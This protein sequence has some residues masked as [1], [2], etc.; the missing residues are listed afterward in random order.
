MSPIVSFFVFAYAWSWASWSMAAVFGLGITEPPGLLLYLLGVLGPLV[1]AAWIARGGGRAA[2]R[3]LLRRIVDPRGIAVRWW[4]ALLAV[5]LGPAVIA[6]VGIGLTG[7]QAVAEGLSAAVVLAMVG[8]ALVAGVAEEPGWRG[9]VAAAWQLRTRPLWA[10]V[11]IGVLWS[12]WHLPLSW[13]EGSYYHDLGAG[14]LRVWLTHLMLVVLGILL[15]WLANGAGSTILLAVLAHAGFN[16]AIGLVASS[17][18]RDVIVLLA[19]TMIAVTVAVATNGR[20]CSPGAGGHERLRA[21]VPP[22]P[23]HDDDGRQP[24]AAGASRRTRA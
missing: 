4:L 7:R 16:V 23:R 14:S 5:A 22:G 9:A 12:L 1:A 13:V 8:P 20:L 18:T 11:G 19:L 17:T 21:S 24:P 15:V 6:A 3:E 2:R 10:A